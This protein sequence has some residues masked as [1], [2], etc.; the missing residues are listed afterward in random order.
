LKLLRR[1]HEASEVE[2]ALARL[3]Q[4]G[5]LDDAGYARSIVARRAG[6][7]GRRAI[8]AELATKG[9]GRALVETSLESLDD[10][11]EVAAAARLIGRRPPGEAAEKSLARL[12]RRGFSRDVITRAWRSRGS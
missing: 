1:G 11:D 4:L 8:A 7:R 5:Y 10:D 2:E 9:I 12:A 6:D 3:A